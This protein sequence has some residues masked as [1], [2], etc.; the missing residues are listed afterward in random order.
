[1][2]TVFDKLNLKDQSEILVL[3]APESFVPELAK[4]RGV[5]IRRS[6]RE[7][8][9]IPFVLAFVTRKK[10]VDELSR[11]LAERAKGDAIVWFAYPKGTSKKYSCDFNRDNGWDVIKALG[12]DTVRAVAIDEDWSAL[13]MRRNEFI[14]AR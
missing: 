7:V 2:P 9:E 10:E 11:P 5:T 14:K 13:R 8:G 4:L 12:F 6:L 1:M 3:N